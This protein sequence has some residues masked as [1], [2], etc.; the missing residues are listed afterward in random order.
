MSAYLFNGMDEWF[1]KHHASTFYHHKTER[2]QSTVTKGLHYGDEY[3][4]TKKI[5]A[6]HHIGGHTQKI[7]DDGNIT[8]D[9]LGWV[10]KRNGIKRECI[11]CRELY[12]QLK[13]TFTPPKHTPKP[14]RAVIEKVELF[15]IES[16]IKRGLK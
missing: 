1:E 6:T 4:K 14:K 16:M 12:G 5:T 11:H 3:D 15:D 8:C 2:K 9:C 10:F 7:F 13:G